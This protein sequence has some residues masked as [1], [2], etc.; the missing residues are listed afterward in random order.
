[1]ASDHC[2]DVVAREFAVLEHTLL[3]QKSTDEK[4][5][6]KVLDMTTSSVLQKFGFVFA[7]TIPSQCK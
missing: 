5:L 2:D 7:E 1:M 4:L 6:E 3:L